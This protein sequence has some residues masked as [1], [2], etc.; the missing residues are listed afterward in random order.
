MSDSDLR[1]LYRGILLGENHEKS[2][3]ISD[4]YKQ[5]I[6]ETRTDPNAKKGEATITIFFSHDSNL[7]TQLAA[8]PGV[9]AREMSLKYFN[10]GVLGRLDEKMSKTVAK[11]VKRSLGGKMDEV[12]LRGI[13]D[14][15]QTYHISGAMSENLLSRILE[16]ETRDDLSSDILVNSFQQVSTFDLVPIIPRMVENIKNYGFKSEKNM[17]EF[18]NDLWDVKDVEGRTSVGRGELAMCVLSI[19][20]KGE[21]G[22]VKAGIERQ[23]MKVGDNTTGTSE[24]AIE[25]KGSGGRPGTDDYGKNNFR[26]D[27][28][29]VLSKLPKPAP[30][31]SANVSYT[32]DQLLAAD[33]A[34]L[35]RFR[36]AT[37]DQIEKVI[38]YIS[39]LRWKVD[40]VVM[41]YSEEQLIAVQELLQGATEAPGWAD[42]LKGYV[43][44][45]G[46]PWKQEALKIAGLIENNSTGKNSSIAK[47]NDFR[48]EVL[49]NGA[50]MMEDTTDFRTAVMAFF[51]NVLPV[52]IGEQRPS[53]EA[54]ADLIWSLRTETKVSMP[55]ELRNHLIGLLEGGINTADEV[56]LKQLVG[57]IQMTSYCGADGFTH[58][59]FVND[60]DVN[61]TSLVVKTDKN[62]LLG[63]FINI[64]SAFQTHGVDC[65]L[66]IDKQ[67][68]GV[69]IIFKGSV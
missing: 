64:F 58:A 23:R 66:S 28:I 55:P 56:T 27:A 65:P 5:I 3:S 33:N 37:E 29:K 43:E 47:M 32:E 16:T 31:T 69:Q 53:N 30:G 42:K 2:S 24:L 11:M 14:T 34:V 40:N 39:S 57:A 15:F 12:A 1:N 62:N 35:T 19:A 7:Q 38:E 63:T 46:K 48:Q 10:A 6:T 50:K 49:S 51:L 59:M 21:P 52:L 22:D 4:L 20:R 67:N 17:N 41:A 68:K 13:Y 9:E 18:I 54:I 45:S 8:I 44:M 25:V 61:K 60:D 26:N 36:V